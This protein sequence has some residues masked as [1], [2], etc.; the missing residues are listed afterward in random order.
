[1]L[2]CSTNKSVNLSDASF[3]CL[4]TF[5]QVDLEKYSM[6]LL[7]LKD[8]ASHVPVVVSSLIL[9]KNSQKL[10][11]SQAPSHLHRT[12]ICE[13]NRTSYLETTDFIHSIFKTNVVLYV[14]CASSCPLHDAQ[15]HK[16]TDTHTVLRERI[17]AS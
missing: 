9:N 8:S 17:G 6:C 5:Q 15:K 12:R 13:H 2:V 11:L 7:S 3:R 4:S 10:L 16:L 1:M 14:I